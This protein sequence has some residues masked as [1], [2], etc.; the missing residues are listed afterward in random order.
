MLMNTPYAVGAAVRGT[1]VRLGLSRAE[2]GLRAGLS[3]NSVQMLEAGKANPTL[4]TLLRLTAVLGLDLTAEPAKLEANTGRLPR[5]SASRKRSESAV[6]RKAATGAVNAASKKP[7]K[8]VSVERR[9]TR[10]E[11][12]ATGDRK[13]VDLDMHLQSFTR[14]DA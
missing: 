7:P 10:S 4:D 8:K 13:S 2:L 5:S 12:R 3:L 11:P 9:S 14:S 6:R 1:R